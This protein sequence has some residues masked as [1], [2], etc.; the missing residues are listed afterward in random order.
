MLLTALLVCVQQHCRALPSVLYKRQCDQVTTCYL[1]VPK[2]INS[3]RS[4]P[5]LLSA[6]H[7]NLQVIFRAIKC[8]RAPWENKRTQRPYDWLDIQ[9][10]LS[11]S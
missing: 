1:T 2:A 4:F 9:I 8:N 7:L 6:S 3:Q 5:A 10:D 11:K